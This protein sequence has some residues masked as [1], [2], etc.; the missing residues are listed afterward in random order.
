LIVA[1]KNADNKFAA[2]EDASDE[3]LQEAHEELK[4][5]AGDALR[6]RTSAR[7]THGRAPTSK[8]SEHTTGT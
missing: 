3:E 8:K 7:K 5:A 4:R 1:L 6:R 2:I